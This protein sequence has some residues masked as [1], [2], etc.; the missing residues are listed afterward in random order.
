MGGGGSPKSRQKEQNQLICDSDKGGGVIKSENFADVTYGS[1]LI[2]DNMLI[3]CCRNIRE[4]NF[5]TLILILILLVSYCIVPY[6]SKRELK[7]C[8]FPR[9]VALAVHATLPFPF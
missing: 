9:P 8:V 4:T 5:L 3:C 7:G 6:V 2:L 1:S